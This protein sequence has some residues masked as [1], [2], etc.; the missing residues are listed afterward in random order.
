MFLPALVCVSV[1]VCLSLREHVN[2]KD[3]GRIF[4]N[5][6]GR[7]LGGKGTDVRVLLRSVE[8]VEVTVEKFRKRAI[9]YILYF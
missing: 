8:D 3:C 9:V 1:L 4:P 2:Y 7:F 6:V 5:F